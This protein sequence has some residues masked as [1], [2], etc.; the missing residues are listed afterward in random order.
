MIEKFNKLDNSKKI[1][2]AIFTALVLIVIIILFNVFYGKGSRFEHLKEDSSKGFVYTCNS[3]KNNDFNINV[4][5]INIKDS[6]IKS[7]NEDINSYV[8]EFIYNEMLNLSY[9]YG[10]NG[11]VLSLIIK[12]VDYNVKDDPK[13]YFKSYNINLETM[14]L[15]NEDEI[16]NAYEISLDDVEKAI[17]KKFDTW[18][19]EIVKEGYFDEDDCDY[20]CFIDNHGVNDYTSEISYYIDSGILV[21][22]KPFTFYTIFGEEDYFKEDNFKFVIKES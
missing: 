20:E 22:Y 15:V 16:L 7:I 10:I 14:K 1:P 2:I 4:P 5:C 21:I 9:E 12:V 17:Y 3:I 19:K 13:V 6:S 11:K 8:E 18:Y